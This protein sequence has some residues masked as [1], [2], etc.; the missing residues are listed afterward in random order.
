MT[1]ELKKEAE[2]YA[3]KHAFRVPYDGSNKFYDDVD[4]KA[5]KDGY[6][7]GAE[8]REKRIADLEKENA[9]L[10][11]INTH[12][13]SRLNLDNG[14]L[15]IE[16]EKLKKENAELKDDNKACKFAMAMSEKA[17][18]AKDKKIEELE[19]QIEKMKCCGNCNK[20]FCGPEDK[21]ECGY[22]YKYWELRS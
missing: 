11:E 12:T 13:L 5:S 16:N 15:I 1:E 8:P 6:L 19:A 14:E 18:K 3:D 9:R 4:F 21:K 2:E 20:M 17:E 22:N 7:A 10:K